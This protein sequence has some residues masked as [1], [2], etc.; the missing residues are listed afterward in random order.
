MLV[1]EDTPFRN[2]VLGEWVRDE[3]Y[4]RY[5]ELWLDYRRRLDC[6]TEKQARKMAVSVHKE[7]FGQVP[8]EHNEKYQKAKLESLRIIERENNES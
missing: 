5:L 6:M 2:M 1:N 3:V 4:E 8:K 7:L